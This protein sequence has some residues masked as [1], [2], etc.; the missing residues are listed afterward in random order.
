[1]IKIKKNSSLTFSPK[2]VTEASEM[3]YEKINYHVFSNSPIGFFKKILDK[4][5]YY[6]AL[7]LLLKTH[8]KLNRIRRL[9]SRVYKKR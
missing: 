2:N 7:T 1:M 4:Y 6:K 8:F 9:Y 5:T 3:I